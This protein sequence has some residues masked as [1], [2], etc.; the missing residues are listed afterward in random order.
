[1]PAL[2]F[3]V[4]GPLEVRRDGELLAIPAPRQRALLG[5]LLLNANVPVPQDQLID[6]LW[7]EDA[8][9]TARAS[10]QNQVSALRKLLGRQT[11]ERKPGGYV[12]HVEAG[13]LDLERFERLLAEARHAESR[14]RAAKLR[15]AL[16]LWRGPPLVEFP[17]EPFAQ[18]EITR[19]EEERLTALED[20]IDVDLEL[21]E[22]VA[23][24][25][26]LE[27]L[28][29]R[30]PLRER[31]W[32]QLML[33]LY[34]TARQ[35]DAL[36]TYR[37]AH[38]IFADELGVGPGLELREL[39]RAI[40]VQEPALDDPEHRLGWTLERAAAIL[41]G[42]PRERAESLYEYALA[43]HRTG[44]R[45]RG[46]STLE[47]AERLAVAAG[48]HG[49]AERARLYLSYLSIWTEG[50]SC[51]DHLAEAQEAARRFEERN[52]DDGLWLAL[53]QQAQMLDNSGQA[54]AAL[55]VARRSLRLAEASGNPWR[56]AASR[57]AVA[58]ALANGTTPVDEAIAW[59]ESELADAS[60]H[61][62][63]PVWCLWF[64]LVSL[65]AQDGRI[66]EAR[67]LGQQAL[68][69]ARRE[70][71]LFLVLH[72][73]DQLAEAELVSGNLAEAETHLRAASA[74]EEPEDDRVVGPLHSA[75]LACVLARSG[76]HAS[77]RQLAVAAR[78]TSLPD[79]LAGEVLWRRAMALVAAHDGRRDEAIQVSEEARARANAS[80]WLTFRGQTAEEAAV[81][82]RLVG[83]SAGESEALRE[84]L[85]LYERKGNVVSV[86]RVRE[87]LG[88]S[89]PGGRT[90]RRGAQQSK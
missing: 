20:R 81:V 36:A 76:E 16:A 82:R 56:R 69:R 13:E 1:M 12:L 74:I 90:R 72:G 18:Y 38:R 77:A 73:M 62:A 23:L 7:G 15:S 29:D 28:V 32:A 46:I 78:A 11:L 55:E 89:D 40:L 66:D 10:L 79:W 47:A 33:A 86:Q 87:W 45:R 60:A 31:I 14:E 64:A 34:R 58:H 37:R 9:P 59:C 6:G 67:A 88:G 2:D 65:L 84:A 57:V 39:Q 4:L 24:V 17:T 27:S 25:P 22:H 75:E 41:P 51:L 83:D 21:G 42:E 61:E 63:T 43:L 3:R 49:L 48:E 30:F 5:L 35:A 70:G 85:A 44:E 80:D 52:D 8:P 68:A 53:Q 71:R 50:R 19:L 26:E 54:D